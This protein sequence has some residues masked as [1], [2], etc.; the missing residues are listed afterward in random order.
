MGTVR[1]RSITGKY[2]AKMFSLAKCLVSVVF[3][4]VCFVRVVGHQGYVSRTCIHWKIF[5]QI[6]IGK[7]YVHV[8]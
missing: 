1:K 3:N 8:F 2:I 5:E 7:A 4:L 6:G